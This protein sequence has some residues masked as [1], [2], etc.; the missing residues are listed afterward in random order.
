MKRNNSGLGLNVK[1]TYK[2]K[3]IK[4]H[5]R[6]NWFVRVRYNGKYLSIYGR[7]KQ[8]TY[9]KLKVIAD[10][11]EQEKLLKALEK[12]TNINFVQSGLQVQ[13][14]PIQVQSQEPTKAVKSYTL[15]GWYDEWIASYKSAS[16]R[17]STLR[18]FKTR[19]NHLKHLWETDIIEVTNLML[20]QIINDQNIGCKT[21]DGLQNM[22]KQMFACAFNNRLIES[23]PAQY[24]PRP[25]QAPLKQKQAFTP[26]QEKLF[27]ETCLTDSKFDGFI[28]CVLQGLRKGE[29]LALRPNDFCFSTNTLR[30]DESFDEANPSDLQTKNRASNRKMP[31][32]DLTRKILLKYQDRPQ[33]E[34]IFKMNSHGLQNRLSQIYELAPDLPKLTTHELRHTFITRCY[35]R[36]IDELCLQRWVGHNLGSA[37]TKAVY[38]H[39]SN[40]ILWYEYIVCFSTF[41]FRSNS[42]SAV[43]LPPWSY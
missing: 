27:V 12:L 43:L 31:M 18:G 41:Q 21:R 19:I 11:V 24:L 37:M 25:K 16:V 22:I 15:K 42:N 6:G 20:N 5:A 2:N 4:K 28:V 30:I 17:S 39:I 8:D 34:M 10:K 7:T 3:T 23:N 26:E 40:D 33:D 38:T 29:M 35:E 13:P 36:K 9:D 1:M 14:M 32:F